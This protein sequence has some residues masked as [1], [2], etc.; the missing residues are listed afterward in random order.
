M[1]GEISD[2]QLLIGMEQKEK[3]ELRWKTFEDLLMMTFIGSNLLPHLNFGIYETEHRRRAIVKDLAKPQHL[4]LINLCVS[5]GTQQ[6][7]GS[8][9]QAYVMA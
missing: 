1:V 4:K 9:Q 5:P 6:T 7:V 3:K 2:N 8:S